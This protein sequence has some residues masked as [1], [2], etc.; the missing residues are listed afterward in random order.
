MLTAFLLFSQIFQ[1]LIIAGVSCNLKYRKTSSKD[2]TRAT[3]LQRS[4]RSIT[5]MFILYA[6]LHR[7]VPKILKNSISD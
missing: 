5:S 3:Q 2:F 6:N 1:F 4:N 7:S